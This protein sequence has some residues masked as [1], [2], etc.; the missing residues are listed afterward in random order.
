MRVCTGPKSSLCAQSDR[1][2]QGLQAKAAQHSHPPMTLPF[3]TALTT[4]QQTSAGLT[5]PAPMAMANQVHHDELDALNHVN[6]VVY[7]VWFERLR[8]AFMEHYGIGIIGDPASPRIVIRSG[9]IRYHTEM[10]R[11]ER[12]V[13]T[14]HC[15]AFRTT[16]MTL[17][18]EVWSGGTLRASFTCVMVLLEQDGKTRCVIPKGI[19]DK[20]IKDGATPPS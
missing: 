18:Q 19:K 14:C 12:Y 11:G 1:A 4:A 7:M 5:D 17:R 13:T 9:D 15:T 10:Q 6:N 3:H 2:R 16:S 8:I 20:L